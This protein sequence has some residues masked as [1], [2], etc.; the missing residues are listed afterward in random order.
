MAY[1]KWLCHKHSTPETP[2]GLGWIGKSVASVEEETALGP[3]W[4]FPI[5]ALKVS[6]AHQCP[7]VPGNAARA[8][9]AS[10]PLPADRYDF[11]RHRLDEIR[12]VVDATAPF[13]AFY[14]QGGAELIGGP[15]DLLDCRRRK[16]RIEELIEQLA[17][18]VGLVRSGGPGALADGLNALRQFALDDAFQ[19]VQTL[20]DLP[21]CP[22]RV[23]RLCEVLEA[24]CRH[25]ITRA[26][27]GMAAAL[28]GGAPTDEPPERPAKSDQPRGR[29][30]IK[31]VGGPRLAAWLKAEM[32]RRDHMKL[33]ALH[34]LT[35]LDRHTLR[36]ILN[37]GQV[38]LEKFAQ[39]ADK[40]GVSD[41]PTD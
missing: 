8:R 37:G 26:A 33:Y 18:A 30:K 11:L 41:I 14:D 27:A 24:W 32:E 38:S 36:R 13:S 39:L 4:A 21:G 34:Q 10:E 20:E 25:L 22:V 5:A 35:G 19:C 2:R 31:K 29:Q 15:K 6:G 40:L 23:D 9:T 7:A 1:S 3:D 17:L 12:S 16:Q 28:G